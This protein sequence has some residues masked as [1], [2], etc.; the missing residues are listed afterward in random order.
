MF[1]ANVQEMF[2]A[3]VQKK[4]IQSVTGYRSSALQWLLGVGHTFSREQH[5]I[6]CMTAI[7]VSYTTA[8]LSSFRQIQPVAA[9]TF[10]GLSGCTISNLGVSVHQCSA[11]VTQYY[12][13]K[14][15]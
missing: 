11:L 1:A 13:W 12:V 5:Y 8:V 2:A 14:Q 3:N 6:F 7:Y 9:P 10:S 15:L 4:T